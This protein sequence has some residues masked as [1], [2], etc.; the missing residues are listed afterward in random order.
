MASKSSVLKQLKQAHYTPLVPLELPCEDDI[1]DIEE[2]IYVQ[3][4][5]EFRDYLLEA[6]DLCVGSLEPVTAA[7]PQSHTYLPDV[8]AA[9][10][11]AGV[12]RELIPICQIANGYY[13][14]DME[15]QVVLWQDGVTDPGSW[16]SFWAWAEDIWLDS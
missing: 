9:A 15:D 1:I 12:P 10:W 7:D 16:P 2:T 3:I 11:D 8:A 5:G 4:R 14:L 13:C 6:S